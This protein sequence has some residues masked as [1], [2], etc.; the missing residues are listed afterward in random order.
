[1]W[2]KMGYEQI[3]VILTNLQVGLIKWTKLGTTKTCNFSSKN[4]KIWN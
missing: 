1:M 3:L 4:P 2:N